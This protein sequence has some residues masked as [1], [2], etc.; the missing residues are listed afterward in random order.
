MHVS[1]R[2]ALGAAAVAAV[3]FAIPSMADQGHQTNGSPTVGCGGGTVTWSPTSVWPPNHKMTTV[4]ISYTS[5]NTDNATE[6]QSR[7]TVDA[8]TDDQILPDGSE[9]NGSG[10]TLVDWDGVG[11]TGVAPKGSAAETNAQIRVERS[12]Q[13]QAGRTYTITVTCDDENSSLGQAGTALSDDSTMA[14]L[15]VNVPH[16]QGKN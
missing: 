7:V 10:N 2:T 6:D 9:M 14:Q 13:S 4:D 5:T 15:T 8:I 1:K 3:A 11:N 16:D 12:G